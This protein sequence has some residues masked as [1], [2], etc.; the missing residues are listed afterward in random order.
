MSLVDSLNM[1]VVCRIS[2]FEKIFT[3]SDAHLLLNAVQMTPHLHVS[4]LLYGK[5]IVYLKMIILSI[6]AHVLPSMC[7]FTCTC[8]SGMFLYTLIVHSDH[9]YFYV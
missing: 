1:R 5:C 3:C 4:S 7:A 8:F 6:F 2:V 9:K